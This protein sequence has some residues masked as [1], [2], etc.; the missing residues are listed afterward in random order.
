MRNKSLLLLTALLLLWCGQS[1]ASGFSI[2]EQS[3]SGL[4]V[5]FAGGAAS[6]DDPSTVYFNPAGM[7]LL[8]GQQA[9]VGV[10]YIM[11]SVKFKSEQATNFLGADLGSN[12]S[13]QAGIDKIVPNFYYTNKVS[14]KFAFGLGINAPFGLATEYDDTWVGRYH[15]IE[16]DVM[17]ININPAVAFAVTDKLSIGIG[18]NA[19]Y[20]K[21]TLSSM[22]DGGVAYYQ[23]TTDPSHISDT[24]YDILATNEGDDWGFGYNFGIMYQFN[25]DTRIGM[26]YRSEV[27][28]KLEGEVEADIPTT[29]AAF[30]SA[31]ETQNII[32]RI[33]LPQSASLSAYH[34]INDK[35][36][37]MAD[38]TWTGWSSFDELTIEFDD[39]FG[40][41]SSTTTTENWDD[42]WRYSIGATYQATDALML[43]FGT[44]YDQTPIS[45]DYRTP[46]IPGE[47]RIW[48][49]LGAGYNIL[50]NL[51]LDAAYVHL[52]VDDSKMAKYT[53]TDSD[54]EDYFRGT[55]VGE[56]ENAVDIFSIQLTY[57]F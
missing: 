55:I 2:I 57:N 5:S 24:D 42:T 11:P 4:G 31:F 17:T 1:F 19:M 53:T 26:S 51:V 30:S 48:L 14:E 12:N 45:D 7:M 38:I 40:G 25:E 54:S 46:R 36:A 18:L 56:Y 6:A 37:I 9:T 32:G 16:S 43:R 3:V 52:F 27:K 20:M 21:A 47:D 8:E 23:A 35:L 50:D 29:M 10:H 15:A 41:K 33:T 39:T 28:Q 13:G 22:V 34:Q 49:S 44:A